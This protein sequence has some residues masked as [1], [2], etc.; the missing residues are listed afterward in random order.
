MTPTSK[1][2]M[3]SMASLWEHAESTC[4]LGGSA[5]SHG[6]KFG[7]MMWIVAFVVTSWVIE[8]TD[9]IAYGLLIA[10]GSF[11]T[12]VIVLALLRWQ[13]QRDERRHADSR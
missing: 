1:L 10:S 2:R 4:M 8:Y 5:R 11:M 7:P 12:A 13:R 3:A 9:A 6:L